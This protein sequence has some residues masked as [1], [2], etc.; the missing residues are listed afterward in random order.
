MKKF[1]KGDRVLP[2]G[3]HIYRPGEESGEMYNLLDGWVALYRILPAGRR[4]ILEFALPGHFF[5]YHPNAEAATAHGAQCLTDVS[6]CV[7]PRRGFPELLRKHPEMG[8]ALNSIAAH[9]IDRAYDH[10]TNVGARSARERVANLLLEL[11]LRV[12]RQ[13]NSTTW[14][15]TVDIPLAQHDIADALGLTSVYVSQMLKS[16]R[17]QKVLVFRN[18]QLQILDH[19]A[20][21]D[22][23]D[24][25]SVPLP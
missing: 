18:G 22:L 9:D 12:T 21:A 5:G 3:T 24:L 16:L 15:D 4:Q 8:M 6:V 1:K 23:A 13:K 11:C 20:L 25:D 19:A 14:S 2:A 10:I 17:E 7:F